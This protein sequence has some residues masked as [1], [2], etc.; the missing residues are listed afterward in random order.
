MSIKTSKY[1]ASGNDFVIFEID[2]FH[3]YSNLARK[4]CNRHKGIG[5]DG[6]IVIIKNKSEISNKISSLILDSNDDKIDFAWDFYNS[7]GSKADMC[8]NGSRA[9]ALFA[10]ENKIANK[11]MKFLTG[12]GII[13]AEICEI[14]KHLAIVESELTKPVKKAEN[15][16]ENGFLWSFYDT[17]VPHLVTFVK[18]L[19]DFNIE[20]ARNLRKKYN[21]NV[22]FA[23]FKDEILRV[24]TYERGV[25]DET[26][27]CGTGMAACFITG[28][29][30]FNLQNVVKVMPKSGEILYLRKNDDKIFFKGAVSHSFDALFY[31]E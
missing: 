24:R 2:S 10:Y 25:E 20:V 26:L 29:I 22:N 31:D 8:G 9:A 16:S 21:A 23:S 19:N 13:N 11:N 4:I 28:I 12:A 3:N 30:N 1:N 17:G 7:D 18:D 5:A 27:A 6:L 15:F 14:N